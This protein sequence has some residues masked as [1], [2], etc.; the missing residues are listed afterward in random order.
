MKRAFKYCLPAAIFACIT[1][2]AGCSVFEPSWDGSIGAVL[3]YSKSTRTLTVNS[4]P[5]DS[6]AKK[7]GLKVKDQIIAIGDEPVSGMTLEDMLNAMRGP[8]G[9]KAKLTIIR[10]TETIDIEVERTPFSRP[11]E[12]DGDRDAPKEGEKE[13]LKEDA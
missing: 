8:I 11:E 6:P 4:M 1:M 13:D 7:A 3:K 12:D 9:S 5:E 10:G 2:I